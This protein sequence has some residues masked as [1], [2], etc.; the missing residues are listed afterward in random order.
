MRLLPLLIVL[1]GVVDS[2][3][4]YAHPVRLDDDFDVF[5]SRRF[6][7]SRKPPPPPCKPTSNWR[8]FAKCQLKGLEIE[9]IKDQPKLKLIAYKTQYQNARYVSLYFLIGNTWQQSGFYSELNTTTELL[10]YRA[11]GERYRIDVGYATPTWVTLDEVSSRPALLRRQFAYFCSP[12]LGCPSVM[13]ACDVLVH[14]KAVS[15]FRGEPTWEGNALKVRGNAS[16]TNR[17]CTK[18]PNLIDVS[19]G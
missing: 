11:D 12:T 17:Y 10:G 2:A 3:R 6:K 9:I 4:A 8:K 18:P 14:G 1:A 15:S 7:K 19:D 16:A 13:I 5:E